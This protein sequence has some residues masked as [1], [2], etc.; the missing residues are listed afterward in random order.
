[1]MHQLP[2][3]LLKKIYDFL[4]NKNSRKNF[5]CVDKSTYRAITRQCTLRLIGGVR[6]IHIPEFP[7]DV[8][9][10][11]TPHLVVEFVQTRL[12]LLP[13][14]LRRL[15]YSW[16]GESPTHFPT[17]L[18]D[19][20]SVLNP[21]QDKGLSSL[22]SGKIKLEIGAY[23]FDN[24]SLSTCSCLR[25][26]E[27][28]FED[29][30]ERRIKLPRLPAGLF[31]LKLC[32]FDLRGVSLPTS[33]TKLTYEFC[34]TLP[35]LPP[36]ITALSLNFCANLH[37][38]TTTTLPASLQD[39]WLYAC[40][41]TFRE[42]LPDL[43]H[44]LRTLA[45]HWTNIPERLPPGL[46][47]FR[48]DVWNAPP[49]LHAVQLPD[50]LRVCELFLEDAYDE[51]SNE[52]QLR[53]LPVLLPKT[54]CLRELVCDGFWFMRAFP[55]PLPEG[56]EVLECTNSGLETLPALP[57]T[58]KV[59]NCSHS[60]HLRALPT[61]LPPSLRE[62]NCFYC[63]G[64]KE[65]PPLPPSVEVFQKVSEFDETETETEDQEDDDIN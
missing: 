42:Q 24:I 30:P 64:M 20:R 57:S 19:I 22:P 38:L 41:E 12:P 60:E 16:R 15:D 21:G 32:G 3:E 31:K 47:H 6:H 53:T 14:Y 56:L 36:N 55:S 37:V 54:G 61:P 59:L 50:N 65:I 9:R 29:A 52:N 51:F 44:S 5:L 43:P 27:L 49:F 8:K 35:E 26:L 25:K 33:L 17:S 45:C 63:L 34:D 39:L 11:H 40:D 1:M 10:T 7:K 4:E 46:E 18:S 13:P 62:L 58:L 28:R 48:C 2:D 23:D